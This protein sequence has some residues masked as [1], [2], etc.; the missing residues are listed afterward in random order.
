MHTRQAYSRFS[1][2]STI[3]LEI[4]QN[5]QEEPKISSKM[6][7]DRFVGRNSQLCPFTEAH[8]SDRVRILLM[9]LQETVST[10]SY[11]DRNATTE[12]LEGQA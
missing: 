8:F 7:V 1:G 12:G 9:T 5:P 4:L 11:E 6:L 2:N 10:S 3:N